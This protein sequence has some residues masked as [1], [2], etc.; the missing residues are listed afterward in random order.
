VPT[1]HTSVNSHFTSKPI[2]GISDDILPVV[3][4]QNLEVFMK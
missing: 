3:L 1:V 4:E 2:G